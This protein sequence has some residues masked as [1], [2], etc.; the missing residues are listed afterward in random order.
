MGLTDNG[1]IGTICN[2]ITS[3]NLLIVAFVFLGLLSFSLLITVIVQARKNHEINHETN[4]NEL[5][6]TRGCISAATHQLR[7]IDNTVL[8]NLCTDFYTYACGNWIKTH[9]IQSFDVE[10]TILGDIIDRRNFEIERLLDAPISRTNERSWEYKLKTYYTECL[11]DYA[12]VPNSGTYMIGL[13][14]DN[15]TIDGWF[16][17]DNSVENASQVALLKNQTLYQQ[18]SHIHG[19]FGA[20]AIFGIR[21]RFDENDTSIKRLEFFPAGL[22]MEV[23]D[24]VGT[25][26]VSMS[27]RAALQ[28]YIVEVVTLLAMEA[29]INDTNLSDRAFTVANDVFTVEEFLAESLQRNPTSNV[30][31]TTTL[32]E[33]SAQFSFD[34]SNLM[35]HELGDPSVISI[36]TPI[37][38]SNTMYFTD[39]FGYMSKDTDPLFARM[40]H[41]Y[42][43]WRLISTYIDDLSYEYVHAHRLYLNAYYGHALHTSN[44]VYCTREVI[45]RF[46]LAIQHLYTMNVTRY[47]NAITTVQ[48]IFDSLKNGFKEYINENA[49][50]MVD[51]ETKNIAREKIDKLTAAI[52]Y[53]T[54]ASDDASLDNYYEKFFVNND[55]HLEN[56]YH[57][58]NFHRWSLSNSLQNPNILDHWDY[59]ETRTS[60]LFDYI[61]LFNRLFVIASGMH[62]PLVNSE[63]PWPVNMGS[64]GVLLAQKLFASIDGPDGRTHLPNGTRY[65]WWQSPTIIGYN[66]SRNCI[67]DYYVRDLKT[68]TYNINGAE[69]QIPLAGEPFSPTTLRHIGALRFAYNTLMKSNDIKSFKMPGTNFTSQQTFFLA[70]A[71]TQCYQREEL[72]QLIRTQLGVYDERTALNAALI[73]MPEFAQAFQCQSKENQCFD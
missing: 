8:S 42:L 31:R 38:L 63:W 29:G 48:T 69:I 16:M 27:R 39:A 70:Y 67:T 61:A 11:D 52:G 20:L 40:I 24:Y 65:D 17:F 26:S 47:S 37:Y 72:L 32:Q 33:I 58:H 49:K 41:N 53:A 62:E 4:N 50:W 73:H 44:D 1:K 34:F 57:Y 30:P 51:E 66:N 28:L 54:I 36:L 14:K 21:T 68:L 7:S 15:A 2:R 64:I 6:L 43:R 3:R 18:M 71:Q 59:F 19:D 45:R 56:A 23:N 46:P 10:R 5:C 25:D 22:T 60:R 9:P 12:R 35:A 13:I 55:L